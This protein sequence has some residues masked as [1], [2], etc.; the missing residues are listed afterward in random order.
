[1]A[2]PQD[3]RECVE[4]VKANP[5]SSADGSNAAMYGMSARI[6]DRGMV[7]DILEAYQDALLTL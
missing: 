5:A 7:G 6:P 2:K 4:Q 1:M 3:L